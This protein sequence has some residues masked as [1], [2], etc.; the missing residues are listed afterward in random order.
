MSRPNSTLNPPPCRLNTESFLSIF[1]EPIEPTKVLLVSFSAAPR[2]CP[3]IVRHLLHVT[4]L[5]IGP[6]IN[7][8]LKLKA[9]PAVAQ[10]NPHSQR[11]NITFSPLHP[12]YRIPNNSSLVPTSASSLSTITEC[13]ASISQPTILRSLGT[14]PQLSPPHRTVITSPDSLILT[15][16]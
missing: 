8:V 13:F 5:Q 1:T 6:C 7:P 12:G 9:P 15:A 2:G 4:M 16:R 14:Y 10:P 11:R 3:A